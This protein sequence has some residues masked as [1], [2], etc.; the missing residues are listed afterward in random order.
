MQNFCEILQKC[1]FL[2]KYFSSSKY[3]SSLHRTNLVSNLLLMQNDVNNH[4]KLVD[5]FLLCEHMRNFLEITMLYVKG[6]QKYCDH[7]A[8]IRNVR[9]SLKFL[10]LMHY[11]LYFFI[12]FSF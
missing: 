9:E 1:E 6:M 8:K 10:F 5:L 11:L 4:R 3:N 12:Y 2:N 7:K